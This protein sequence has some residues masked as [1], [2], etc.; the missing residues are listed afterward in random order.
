[1]QA[2]H[3]GPP[4]VPLG[5]AGGKV[6]G[7]AIQVSTDS[8]FKKV[9]TYRTAKTTYTLKNLSKGKTYYVRVKACTK[10][11]DKNVYG[12]A[13]KTIKVKAK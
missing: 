4:T 2:G 5:N 13:S 6:S 7:Y 10:V 3:S 12:A 11:S 8:S 9:T 1:M